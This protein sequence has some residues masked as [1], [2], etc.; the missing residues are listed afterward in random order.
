M[1]LGSFIDI[2]LESRPMWR[3]E[4]PQKGC[5]VWSLGIRNC[6]VGLGSNSCAPGRFMY[7]CHAY[8]LPIS[9]STSHGIWSCRYLLTAAVSRK[10]PVM[11]WLIPPLLCFRSL[12]GEWLPCWFRPVCWK[13]AACPLA[14]LKLRKPQDTALPCEDHAAATSVRSE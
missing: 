4:N 13:S 3:A 2:G 7:V 8:M 5:G 14:S 9:D 11:M 1:T 6:V 12:P 10:P